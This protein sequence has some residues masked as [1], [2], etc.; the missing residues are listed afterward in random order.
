[1]AKKIVAAGGSL[2]DVQELAGHASLQ[3]TQRYIQ[4]DGE[5]KRR[6]IDLLELCSRGL[7]ANILPHSAQPRTSGASYLPRS[8]RGPLIVDGR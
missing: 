5:A 7:A 3:T 1:V 4:V 6:V 8:A 2:R